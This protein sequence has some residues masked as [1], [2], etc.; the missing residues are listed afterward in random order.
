[1]ETFPALP[2]VLAGVYEH[3]DATFT[4]NITK[5]SPKH[6]Q[7]TTK[8]PPM[9]KARP[10][11]HQTTTKHQHQVQP[12]CPC[13]FYF[14]KT[15]RQV[16]LQQETVR[17]NAS[18]H[19]QEAL[20]LENCRPMPDGDTGQPRGAGPTLWDPQWTHG[21]HGWEAWR[22][23]NLPGTARGILALLPYLDEGRWILMNFAS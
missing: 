2:V 8:T 6:D 23:G 19:F 4:P 21:T 10:N 15:F 17:W 9:T 11:Y 5:T 12:P 18:S 16:D 20:A 1:M 3:L 14:S 13:P 22:V 7:T